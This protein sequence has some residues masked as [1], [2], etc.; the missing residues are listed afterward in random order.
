MCDQL[1]DEQL[2]WVFRCLHFRGYAAEKIRDIDV[3]QQCATDAI[4]NPD[5]E[6]VKGPGYRSPDFTTG[7]KTRECRRGFIVIFHL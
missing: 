7:L 2:V 4:L 5:S 3:A 1:I 6:A